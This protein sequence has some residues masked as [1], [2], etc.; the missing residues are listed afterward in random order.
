MAAGRPTEYKEE[1]NEQA[2]K[3]CL[4]GAI[5][6]DLADFFDVG[7]STI[8]NW[9]LR[10]PEFME[11]IKRGKQIA[12][13]NVADKLYQRATGYEHPELITASFQ[14]EITDE[15]EVIKHY[16]PDPVAAIF[17]LKNRQPDKWR[18]KQEIVANINRNAALDDQEIEEKLKRLLAKHQNSGA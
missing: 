13:A 17:W 11:S 6:K 8:N 5:D 12:D 3:L 18:D 10:Y 16:A 15:K 2:Y 1:Y 4:L 9:K 7:E 14:G